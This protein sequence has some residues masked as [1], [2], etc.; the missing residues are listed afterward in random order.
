MEFVYQA[1]PDH[2]RIVVKGT[3]DPRRAQLELGNIVRQSVATGTSR[4]LLDAR[5][6]PPG[7]SIADRHDL[8]VKLATLAPPTL[9]LA[10][11]VS[12]DNLFTKTL[13]DTALNRGLKV[14][15]TASEAEAAA[16]LGL[17]PSPP[18]PAPG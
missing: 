13:E 5:E 16:Y 17:N 8:A 9:R 18:A 7:V 6:I 1:R 2:L 12:P 14:R 10:I 11:L 4:I 15:T 3:F